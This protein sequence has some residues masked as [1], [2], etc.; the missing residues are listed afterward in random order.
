MQF[1]QF[2]FPRNIVIA[3][4]LVRSGFLVLCALLALVASPVPAQRLGDDRAASE[5]RHHLYM[6]AGAYPRYSSLQNPL[7]HTA[8]TFQR[9][10]DLFAHN[11]AG[12]HGALGLGDGGRGRE[13]HPPPANLLWFS[14][15][16]MTR[17][18]A[19][20]FWSIAEGGKPV[21]SAM[22]AFRTLM[23]K[24]DIWA[25]IAFIQHRLGNQYPRPLDRPR[26]G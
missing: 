22:P 26:R 1:Q 20:L 12:C 7:P 21:G 19:Y 13:L 17:Q 25:V 8:L 10:A 14:R 18:D 9:G 15:M 5:R 23:T 3:K 11:C 24:G 2:S 16:P 4:Q 6:M